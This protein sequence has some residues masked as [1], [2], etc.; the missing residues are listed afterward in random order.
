M[1]P[2]AYAIAHV[3]IELRTKLI[4]SQ[5][6]IAWGIASKIAADEFWPHLSCLLVQSLGNA[7]RLSMGCPLVEAAVAAPTPAQ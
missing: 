4:Q 5:Q 2:S 7:H 6:S 1:G 3:L